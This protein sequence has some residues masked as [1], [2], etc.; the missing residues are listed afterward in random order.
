MA[1]HQPSARYMQFAGSGGNAAMSVAIQ[2][3][4]YIQKSYHN[5]S[6][7][8]KENSSFTLLL[9]CTH[10]KV[11]YLSRC[12]AS[13][14]H[15]Y[16]YT[17]NQIRSSIEVKMYVTKCNGTCPENSKYPNNVARLLLSQ[18]IPNQKCH[19]LY[20]CQILKILWIPGTIL[21]SVELGYPK[22]SKCTVRQL[23]A[24]RS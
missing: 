4:D 21:T 15:E 5:L 7:P 1:I 8:Y 18:W 17:A 11:Q 19:E 2:D 22:Q 3:C 20:F 6:Y 23:R 14:S 10:S 12:S 24:F 9:H 13:T 16:N